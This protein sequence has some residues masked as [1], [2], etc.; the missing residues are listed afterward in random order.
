MLGRIWSKG[1]FRDLGAKLV[2]G[3][4]LAIFGQ[5]LHCH[6]WAIFL[7][8]RFL[9][10]WGFLLHFVGCDLCPRW[11][12]LQ[13]LLLLCLGEF[14]GR[15]DFFHAWANFVG[16][17][18]CGGR[19]LWKAKFVGAEICGRQNSDFLEGLQFLYQIWAILLGEE[20]HM[21]VWFLHRRQVLD[22]LRGFVF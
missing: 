17:E 11:Q 16:A 18:F 9:H 20:I 3:S 12:I 14:C 2:E 4:F 10:F 6:C 7:R 22:K 5:F 8:A 1:R 21:K 15:A 19:N 13:I